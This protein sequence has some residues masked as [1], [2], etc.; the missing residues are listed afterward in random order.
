MRGHLF[1][2][3]AQSKGM[4][5]WR[6]AALALPHSPDLAVSRQRAD[7]GGMCTA[8]RDRSGVH[9]PRRGSVVRVHVVL[10]RREYVI[11]QFDSLLFVGIWCKS[12]AVSW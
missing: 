2:L 8:I 12:E 4:W 1:G 7:E 11:V 6:I 9:D 10:G 5:R 3:H